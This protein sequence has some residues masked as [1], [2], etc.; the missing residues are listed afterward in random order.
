MSPDNSPEP[1]DDGFHWFLKL[2]SFLTAEPYEVFM[3]V[4]LALT[5]LTSLVQPKANGALYAHLPVWQVHVW[6]LFLIVGS[7]LTFAGL[8]GASKAQSVYGM[9]RARALERSGQLLLA[10]A[11][12]IW[13]V[14]LFSI[15]LPAVSSALLTLLFA[16]VC[17]VRALVLKYIQKYAMLSRIDALKALRL[18]ES[19]KDK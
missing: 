8:V 10:W 9:V 19:E 5:G 14:V 3:A 6:G 11:S 1:E 18:T 17:T 15:G 12:L 16:I 2:P 4:L 13:S 7:L